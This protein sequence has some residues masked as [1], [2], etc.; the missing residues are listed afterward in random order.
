VPTWDEIARRTLAV[1]AQ[2]RARWVCRR[3]AATEFELME[4]D[5]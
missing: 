4:K 1:Y 2:A 3:T 5:Q